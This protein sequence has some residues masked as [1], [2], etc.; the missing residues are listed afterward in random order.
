MRFLRR[1]T[2]VARALLVLP[3]ASHP[4]IERGTGTRGGGGGMKVTPPKV[5]WRPSE[6]LAGSGKPNMLTVIASRRQHVLR[7]ESMPLAAGSAL[8]PFFSVL[9]SCSVVEDL[10]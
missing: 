6:P 5:T 7:G 1:A 8:T 3:R 10:W 9:M 2:G 4:A